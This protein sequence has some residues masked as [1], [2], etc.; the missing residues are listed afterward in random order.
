MKSIN[1][2]LDNLFQINVLPTTVSIICKNCINYSFPTQ[3][4]YYFPYCCYKN[5]VILSK[6]SELRRLI[7]YHAILINITKGKANR[8]KKLKRMHDEVN[9]RFRLVGS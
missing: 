7:E 3:T 6:Y 9:L 8:L 5:K 4:K 2:N 1:P